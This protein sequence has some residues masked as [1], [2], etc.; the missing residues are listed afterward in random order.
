VTDD[1]L[2][3]FPLAS[4]ATTVGVNVLP[5]L[6]TV[7]FALVIETEAV[8]PATVVV[9]NESG[10][11]PATVA[12]KVFVPT[13]V[14]EVIEA[15]ALPA[16][17]VVAVAG[18]MEPPPA[19]DANV[20]VT[21]DLGFPTA[22]VTTTLTQFAAVA[23]AMRFTGSVPAF[24]MFAAGPAT[25]VAE[26]VSGDPVSPAAVAVAVFVV[27]V[28]DT[29]NTVLAIPEASL[30]AVAGVTEP[31]PAVTANV[32]VVPDTALPNASVTLTLTVFELPAAGDAGRSADFAI[33]FAAPAETVITAGG[34]VTVPTLA[35]MFAVP[36]GP[37]AVTRPDELTVAM[38][39]AELLYETVCPCSSV[40]PAFFTTAVSCVVA[41]P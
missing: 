5:T 33:V 38:L 9:E 22:S 6:T 35:V 34:E 24:A 20:T 39:A 3:V 1:A 25:V 11:K 37:S 15:E 40:P 19:V 18:V 14:P 16:A 2:V 13:V 31:P 41:P 30:V 27:S 32:T 12:V 7:S 36:A 21:P 4:F 23:P 8:G 28:L 26:N 10:V 29:L 17:S